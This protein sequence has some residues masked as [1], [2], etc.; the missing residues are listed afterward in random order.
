MVRVGVVGEDKVDVLEEGDSVDRDDEDED[1][2]RVG[3]IVV[4]RGAIKASS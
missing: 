3:T 2:D 1:E 4:D